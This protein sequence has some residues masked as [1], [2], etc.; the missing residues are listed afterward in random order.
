LPSPIAHTAAGYLIY[1]LTERKLPAYARRRV[2]RLPALL[3]V[4]TLFSMLPD[5]DAVLGVVSGDMGRFHNNGTHSLVLGFCIA[6]LVAGIMGWKKPVEFLPWFTIILLSYES[7]VLMDFFTHEGRGVMLFWP[8]SSNRYDTTVTLF[9]GVRWS[10]GW[11]TISH[12][13][14]IISE[15]FFVLLVVLATR[16]RE[17]KTLAH[18]EP[19]LE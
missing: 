4:T 7:H 2:G 12:L 1:H 9:Y 16:V 14:T 11:F 19:I 15:F 13:W 17:R 3:M 5:L 10:Q 8:L 6:L 18:A